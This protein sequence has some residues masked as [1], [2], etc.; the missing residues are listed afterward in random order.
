MARTVS[1]AIAAEDK[2][3]KRKI[4]VIERRLKS[5]SIWAVS[6]GG[7]PLKEPKRWTLRIVNAEVRNGRVREM[8]HDKGWEFAEP[9]DL[10]VEPYEVGFS[11]LDGRIVRGQH[12]QEVLMKMERADYAEVVKLK[13]QAVR[14]DTFGTK[15]AKQTVL[16]AAAVEDPTGNASDFLNR[17]IN[18]IQVEDSIER[19]PIEE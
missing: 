11:I 3:K 1:Q 6:A 5:G 2:P 9:G 15:A 12:S 18:S 7:I 17:A 8:Q 19:I 14:K 4:S 10:A 13:E 16:N